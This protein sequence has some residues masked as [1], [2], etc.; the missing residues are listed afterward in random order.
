MEK[1]KQDAEEKEEQQLLL[2][3]YKSLPKLQRTKVIKNSK[4]FSAAFV[5]NQMKESFMDP[6]SQEKLSSHTSNLL[7]LARSTNDVCMELTLMCHDIENAYCFGDMNKSVELAET[8]WQHFKRL[9]RLPSFPNLPF[10]HAKLATYSAEAYIG[11]QQFGKAE[12]YLDLAQLTLSQ[13]EPCDDSM[14][15]LFTMVK[16]YRD[17]VFSSPNVLPSVREKAI[18]SYNQSF[19]DYQELDA[20]GRNA[21]Y[22]EAIDCLLNIARV[23]L[24]SPDLPFGRVRTGVVTKKDIVE[25]SIALCTA[26]KMILFQAPKSRRFRQHIRLQL[27]QGCLYYR[28][29]EFKL[30]ETSSQCLNASDKDNEARSMF[31]LAIIYVKNV[32]H[33]AMSTTFSEKKRSEDFLTYLECHPAFIKD[34]DHICTI[35]KDA[36]EKQP[37]YSSPESDVS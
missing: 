35:D 20:E 10:L 33:Q 6:A 23:H 26:E 37:E 12:D 21:F 13:T 19:R 25:A 3:P 7:K 9:Q 16:Y 32:K 27:C 15:T 11:A 29:A 34:P 18:N 17:F 28:K 31:K 8:A 36:T 30:A 24:D 1:Q 5:I 22:P 14:W 2:M 4:Y